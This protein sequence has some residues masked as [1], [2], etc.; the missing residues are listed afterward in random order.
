[1]T[2]PTSLRR[3]EAPVDLYAIAEKLASRLPKARRPSFEEKRF[4][5]GL[6]LVFEGDWPGHIALYVVPRS[7][8]ATRTQ[9]SFEVELSWSYETQWDEKESIEAE[10]GEYKTPEGAVKRA[11][12]AAKM[13]ETQVRAR[14][15]REYFRR[16]R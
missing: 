10:L 14:F 1:M 11:F 7:P 4:L 13:S 12:E 2:A 3:R 15:D 9:W 6:G 8:S 5:D 16:A